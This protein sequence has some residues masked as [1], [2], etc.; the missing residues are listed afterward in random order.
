MLTVKD[1][2][3]VINFEEDNVQVTVQNWCKPAGDPDGEYVYGWKDIYHNRDLEYGA[4]DNDFEEWL[5]R[6]EVENV[7]MADNAIIVVTNNY[8]A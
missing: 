7:H 2:L 8:T 4:V 1:L 3:N 6:L 5:G